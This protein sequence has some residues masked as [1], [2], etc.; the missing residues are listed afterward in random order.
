M[1]MLLF[2]VVANVFIRYTF[3]FRVGVE[4]RRGGWLIADGDRNFEV[5][6]FIIFDLA[7]WLRMLK[8]L[9]IFIGFL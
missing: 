8:L 9:G 7:S 2:S 1:R 3:F 4:I 6:F 5:F